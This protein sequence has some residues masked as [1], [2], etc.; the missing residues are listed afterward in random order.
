[1][2]GKRPLVSI[3]TPSF[4]QG[5]WLAENLRS[6]AVQTYPDIEHIV[7]DGGS[8]DG[9]IDILRSALPPVTWRSESDNGQSHAI[10]KAFAASGGEIIG[11]INSDD[12]LFDPRVVDR[13]VRYF[14]R[15]P[16]VDVVY[17]H[18]ARITASG[19]VAAIIWA[20]P[21]SERFLTRIDYIVQPAVFMRRSAIAERFLDESFHFAMDWELWL[22]L[23]QTHRIGRLPKVLACD[24]VQP[25]RKIKTWL[26]VLEQDCERLGELYGVGGPWYKYPRTVKAYNTVARLAGLWQMLRMPADLAFAGEQDPLLVRLARQLGIKRAALPDEESR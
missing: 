4:N 23:A 7:M 5:R 3:L 14:E 25:D 26:H 8:T 15:H 12:A 22:R 16:R 10:N 24:R 6:V 1:M 2:T 11:W 20:I 9:S 21:F 18:A 13:V 17:G 19:K